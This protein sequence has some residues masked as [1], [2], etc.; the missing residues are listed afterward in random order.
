MSPSVPADLEI[1]R[2]ETLNKLYRE[3]Q[4]SRNGNVLPLCL[5]RR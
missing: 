3:L 4:I 2:N 1:R 5:Y